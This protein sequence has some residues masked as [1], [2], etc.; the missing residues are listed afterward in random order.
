MMRMVSPPPASAPRLASR[1]SISCEP[2]PASGSSERSSFGRE[3]IARVLGRE[4][5]GRTR[6]PG[7]AAGEVHRPAVPIARAGEALARGDAALDDLREGAPLGTVV[8]DF[9]RFRAHDPIMEAAR[10]LASIDWVGAVVLA[11]VL[12]V[13]GLVLLRFLLATT[14]EVGHM[15]PGAGEAAAGEFAPRR[16]Q[17]FPAGCGRIAP[18]RLGIVGT[19][20]GHFQPNS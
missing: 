2:R 3:A 10:Y 19:F 15:I 5:A 8:A 6:D 12:V 4:H 16:R 14:S 17:Q 7:H 18:L 1:R 11:A 13:F 20:F 9:A